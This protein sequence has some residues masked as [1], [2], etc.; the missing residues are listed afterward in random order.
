MKKMFYILLP[1]LLFCTAVFAQQ[2]RIK[3]Q[4]TS[5]KSGAERVV[6]VYTVRQFRI[7]HK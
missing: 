2:A 1:A 7:F 3:G 6:R 5:K 4:A